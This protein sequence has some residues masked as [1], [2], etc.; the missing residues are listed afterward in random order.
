[1]A[2]N[3]HT[4]AVLY[5]MLVAVGLDTLA[6]GHRVGLAVMV[7]VEQVLLLRVLAVQVE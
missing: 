1:L 6:L 4:Q 5:I 2:F 7:A 3:L